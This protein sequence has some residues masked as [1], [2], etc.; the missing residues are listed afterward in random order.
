MLITAIVLRGKK[1]Y[2]SY[3]GDYQTDVAY[4]LGFAS[5]LV[6]NLRWMARK[7]D[8][9]EVSR[10]GAEGT[11]GEGFE[12]AFSQVFADN[13]HHARID[14]MNLS[15]VLG[16][17]ADRIDYLIQEVIKE[18]KR[19]AHIRAY[20][21][22]HEDWWST[23]WD[24]FAG[25]TIPPFPAE[26][27]PTTT[28]QHLMVLHIR[29]HSR[30]GSIARMGI[31]S[32]YP[33]RLR[34][35][36][37]VI[38]AACD[39]ITGVDALIADLHEYPSR[40]QYGSVDIGDLTQNLRRWLEYNRADA[41]WLNVVAQAFEEAGGGGD[42]PV[43]LSDVAL[44]AALE[45]QGVALARTPLDITA[46]TLAGIDPATGYVLDPVNAASGSFIEPE[47]DLV[48]TG[49]CV[50]LA[51]TRMYNSVGDSGGVFGPHWTSVL[52]QQLCLE[53]KQV[54]WVR[55]DGR[56]I[57]F[58]RFGRG[59][60][61]AVQDHYWCDRIPVN[62]VPDF[63]RGFIPAHDDEC[64]VVSDNQGSCWFY[65]YRGA[66]LGSGVGEGTFVCAQRREDGMIQALVHERGRSITCEYTNGLCVKVQGSDGRELNYHYDDDSRLI[67]VS[68][69][70]GERRYIL[71][72][73]GLIEQ[74]FSVDGVREVTNTYDEVGRVV[75]QVTD[76]GRK[77]RFS[78][79]PGGV[80]EVADQS[81]SRANAWISNA[82]GRLVGVIDADGNR[83]SMSYDNCGNLVAATN[84]DGQV[85]VH[86]YDQRGRRTRTVLPSGGEFTFAW[87]EH[88]RLSSM[89]T[90]S[91]GQVS[92]LYDSDTQRHPSVI[93][94]PMGGQTSLTWDR[95]LL[96][97]IVDPMGVSASLGYDA[98]GD[99]VSVTNDQGACARFM[100][101]E[102]GRVCQAVAP[103]GAVTRLEYDERGHCVAVEHPD[104]ARWSYEFEGSHLVATVDPYGARTS[105]TY[106]EHG[107]PV[108]VTD[109]L[110]RTTRR[111]FD[112]CGNVESLL[113]PDGAEYS[114]VHDALS[115][116]HEL[117]TPDGGLWRHEWDEMGNLARSTDPTGVSQ[118]WA[119]GPASSPPNA[120]GASGV[121]ANS[122]AATPA[123]SA[124][125]KSPDY[126]VEF[127]QYGRPTR[128]SG[129][130]GDEG[131]VTYDLA[132]N[133]VEFLDADGGLTLFRRDLAGR[134]VERISPE[135]VSV[136]YTYDA[137]GRVEGVHDV[138]GTTTF[139]YD[140]CSRVTK[141]IS[142]TGEESCF[143]YDPVGR[144]VEAS[145]P[146]VGR[147]QYRYDLCGRVV[148]SRE[149]LTGVRR[150][151][152]DQAGQLVRAVNGVGGTTR[153]EYDVMGRLRVVI[154]PAGGVSR[155]E[156]DVAGRLVALTDPLGNVTRASYDAAGRLVTQMGP[157]GVELSFEYNAA[158]ERV[159]TYANGKLLTRVERDLVARTVR[160]LDHT[161]PDGRATTHEL[162]FDHAGR[163]V[164]R[165]H[166]R[167]GQVRVARW[168]YDRDG[169]RSAFINPD[170]ARTTYTY[171]ETGRL[172]C[173]EHPTLGRV[174]LTYDEAGRL[175]RA[176]S[177]EGSRHWLYEAGW[178]AAHWQ[179]EADAA[180][181]SA[182][183]SYDVWGR[184]STVEDA[185]VIYTY[186]Y[187]DAHQLCEVRSSA[188]TLNQW[189]YDQAGRLTRSLCDGVETVFEYDQASQLTRMTSGGDSTV[190][191]YD[192]K[193]RRVSA[194]SA[195]GKRVHY[196]WDARNWL[197]EIT[198]R[199]AGG[200]PVTH[201]LWVDGLGEL[202]SVNDVDLTWDSAS[203]YPSLTGVNGVPLMHMPGGGNPQ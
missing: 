100:R 78:Y 108:S 40:C 196:A 132:G 171:D 131:I 53:D 147:S 116:L 59:F 15:F 173:V 35:A 58:P 195:S 101:D 170:G 112:D 187:D 197:A 87:D 45:A 128:W 135:G 71:G 3:F 157:D 102:A 191:T 38:H 110:G 63:V 47:V 133:P 91:G 190:Y 89:V 151:S 24:W 172:T 202:N 4:D 129:P 97:R 203:L 93:V 160:L 192:Q 51:F 31:S 67:G 1:R 161:H 20:M 70:L 165:T 42:F 113:L 61:R 56:H 168:E 72:V 166:E 28:G 185:G 69:Q 117:R 32:A 95:G 44:L 99:L 140:F 25:T 142:P 109:P 176:N 136:R 66:W 124:D 23:I 74:V 183:V 156:Y 73:Q 29:D 81:G 92:Y 137:C 10:A 178:L 83:Q 60:E 85:T 88:D 103:D 193:G 122:D 115:R 77:V 120:L 49:G 57:L 162:A 8:D 54:R 152:Y 148:F 125:Q 154:D 145:I 118:R 155:R 104:G 22:E 127:D 96:S 189:E 182:R 65:D 17:V 119:H 141:R 43:S 150:F 34:S 106:G 143:S 159:A 123:I 139:E 180:R 146:G 2:V 179:D 46:P 16:I 26:I 55:D 181:G 18:N 121:T 107:Q 12:G 98:F 130:A 144:L 36:A 105:V 52:D 80:T 138:A 186:A 14:G 41:Q 174:D 30:T 5:E 86:V 94:D 164:S 11:A 188:G 48:F 9:Y 126:G 84:R 134:V 163:L 175:L 39:R 76:F 64:F 19:R 201:R 33:A 199:P 37:T 6:C 7:I 75:S 114:F 68:S 79:L 158:G 200:S 198:K 90:G 27:L 21:A 62:H 82:Q 184:V 111:V 169:R 167:A 177:S 13:M 50:S 153:Y 149:P 194:Q